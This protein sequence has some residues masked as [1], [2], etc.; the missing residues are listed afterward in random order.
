MDGKPARITIIT[1]ALNPGPEVR[2]TIESVLG[3]GYPDL[4]YI[5]VDGGS[6]PE[7]FAFVQPYLTRIDHLIQ[8]PDTGISDAWNKGLARATGDV[9]GLINADDF[10]LPGALRSV[11]SVF[12][13]QPGMVLVHGN[14][15]R[16]ENGH[17]F[18]RRPMPIPLLRLALRIGTPVVHPATF[19]ARE[20]YERVGHFDTSYRVAMDYDFVLR[21][22]LA[23]ARFIHLDEAL[24]GFRGG[25][26]SDR[27]PLR[28][29]REVRRSQLDHGLN[30]FTVELLH[31]ARMTVRR[32]VRPLLGMS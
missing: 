1:A 6:R 22:H 30:R 25:G 7:S 8:E 26:L 2:Q 21:A 24:V 19:V 9:I 31:A 15:Q 13:A 18:I 29:F 23:G 14:A 16:I 3:Q 12:A 32:V 11:A 20:V 27:E 5:F 4:Q 10:L 17:N 28:G